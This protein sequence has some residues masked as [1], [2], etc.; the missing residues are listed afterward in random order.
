MGIGI[1]RS[2]IPAECECGA[3]EEESG[4]GIKVTIA[5]FSEIS[6]EG[7]VVCAKCHKYIR[8]LNT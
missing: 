6:R 3:R 8:M 2:G 5:N 1:N 7:D 4:R